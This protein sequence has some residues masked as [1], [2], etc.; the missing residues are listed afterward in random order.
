MLEV[1]GSTMASNAQAL[2]V[3][4]Q[5][6]LAESGWH[7]GTAERFWPLTMVAH[8]DELPAAAYPAR[9]IRL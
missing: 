2:Q 6:A 8:P 9:R 5:F 4:P 1:F 3:Y 7:D